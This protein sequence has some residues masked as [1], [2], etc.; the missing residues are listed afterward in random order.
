MN[1]QKHKNNMSEKIYYNKNKTIL[2]NSTDINNHF[3]NKKKK[4]YK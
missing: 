1:I 3:S 2:K 4:N